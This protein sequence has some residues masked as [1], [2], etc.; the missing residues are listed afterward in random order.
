MKTERGMSLGVSVGVC[1]RRLQG[2]ET[3]QVDVA[4]AEG[5]WRHELLAKG[6]DGCKSILNNQS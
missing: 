1:G 4:Q 6:T 2:N 3:P 5:G